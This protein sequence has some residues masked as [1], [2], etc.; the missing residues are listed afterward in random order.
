M[1]KKERETA[2]NYQ[3]RCDKMGIQS[4]VNNDIK[5]RAMAYYMGIDLGTSS[6]KALLM[7]EDGIVVDTVQAGYDILKPEQQYAEQDMEILWDAAKQTIRSLFAQH[8]NLKDE[9]RGVGYS[10]QMHGLVMIDKEGRLLR[11]AIIWAD[12][13][14]GE[15]ISQIYAK[16]PEDE[17]RSISL[18]SL[19]TGFLVTSLMWVKENEP[20]LYEK[21]D[22]IMLPKDYLRYRMCGE[23]GTDL[24]DA[25]GTAVFDTARRDWAWDLIE[26]LDLDRKIFV[27][28][29]EAHETAGVSSLK[30]EEETG[31]KAGTSLVYGGGDSMMQAVGNG[32]IEPGLLCANIGTASQLSCCVKRPIHDSRYRTNTF[33]HSVQ[34]AWILMGANLSGGVAL[35]WL[36]ENILEMRSFDEMSRLAET[37]LA[38]SGGLLFLPYLNG[39]RTPY[40]DPEAKGIY[41]GLTLKHTRAELIRST[42]EGIVFALRNSFDIFEEMSVGCDRIIA[43][44]GGARGRLFR[45]IQADVFGVEI[46]TNQIKEQACVGAAVTAAV[47]TGGY[48][49]YEEAC[50]R[51]VKM[52]EEIVQPDLE[53]QKIYR[54]RY[55][56]YKEL[57]PRNRG[58]FART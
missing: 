11:N 44:G 5:E 16:V 53:R 35:K 38:G 15:T 46:Y 41:H 33:C 54:E 42:M 50:E 18:N 17:Y 1:R 32:L 10:G 20:S 49:S 8:S 13:R 30:C 22:K 39:E 23:L 19:S 4:S 37:A 36:K 27:P 31:L 9:I 25:S 43:S 12:Q 26:R 47:G 2:E 52:E 3:R 51:I 29:H 57:Y 45:Q 34:D 6:V 14:T 48:G 28:C 56:A 24:S 21:I 7:R 55:E 58:S 40:H